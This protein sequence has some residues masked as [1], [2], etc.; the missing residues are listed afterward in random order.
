LSIIINKLLVPAILGR[1]P[2]GVA[3]LLTLLTINAAHAGNRPVADLVLAAQTAAMGRQLHDPWVILGAASVVSNIAVSDIERYTEED[4]Q[5]PPRSF[6]DADILSV[7]RLTSDADRFKGWNGEA[8]DTAI[9]HIRTQIAPGAGIVARS[10]ERILA[11]EQQTFAIA[12]AGGPL[13]VGMISEAGNL[14]LEVF[15]P[16]A[17]RTTG[18]AAGALAYAD[19]VITSPGKCRLTVVNHASSPAQYLLLIH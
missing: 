17:T 18:G 12:C 10:A 2:I 14:S 19:P 5:P 4:S 1:R 3:V 6:S 8:V 11:G 7:A 13:E 9:H 15:D 16:N